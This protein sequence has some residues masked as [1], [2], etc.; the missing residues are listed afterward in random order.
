MTTEYNE[1]SPTG[2]ESPLAGLMCCWDSERRVCSKF[3][4]EGWKELNEHTH[5]GTSLGDSKAVGV[6]WM[7]ELKMSQR[8]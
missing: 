8:T 4:A 2:V 7:E 3:A 6:R 1:G 5:F